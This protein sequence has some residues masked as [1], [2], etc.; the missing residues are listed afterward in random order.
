MQDEMNDM[1]DAAEMMD[2]ENMDID[3]PKPEK[4]PFSCP[5]IA[6]NCCTPSDEVIQDEKCC[7]CIPSKCGFVMVG[8]LTIILWTLLFTLT[9]CDYYNSYFD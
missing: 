5:C 2:Q 7:C 9:L 6:P 3:K 1:E 8:L 4:K